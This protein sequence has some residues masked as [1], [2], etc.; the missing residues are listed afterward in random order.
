MKARLHKKEFVNLKRVAL[1]LLSSSMGLL[2]FF[3]ARSVNPVILQDEW[4]YLVSSRHVGYWDQA[5]PFDYSNYLFNI[6]YGSTAVCGTDFYSC[7]KGL[8][9]FW[10]SLL[11]F[12]LASLVMKHVGFYYA[13]ATAVA[14]GLSP[15]AV[16]VSLF[17]PEMMMFSLL[18]L[19]F[20]ILVEKPFQNE[21]TNWT[22][23]AGVLGLAALVK[24]H[25]L[26]FGIAV[27]VLLL[28]QIRE[29]GI[30]D[31]SKSVA[32]LAG[33]FL[34]ARFGAGFLVAGPKALD[35]LGS[36]SAGQALSEAFGGATSGETALESEAGPAQ[37]AF[38]DLTW[39]LTA[40]SL[41]TVSVSAIPVAILLIGL[42]G[43]VRKSVGGAS[44]R[45]IVF[46]LII[47][48]VYLIVVS[49]F[50]GWV[51]GTGDDHT[52]RILMRYFDFTHPLL[53][54]TSILAIIIGLRGVPAL[55]NRLLVTGGLFVSSNFAFSGWLATKGIQ[56]ADAP[57]LAG[58][59]PNL[60]ILTIVSL[61][62]AGVLVI[63]AFAWK[64]GKH[65]A[66]AG[67]LVISSLLGVTSMGQ[68][69]IAR[70]E[71]SQADIAGRA[72]QDLKPNLTPSN[73][74]LVS[75]SRFEGRIVSFWADDLYDLQ[76]VPP[77]SRINI[78]DPELNDFKFVVT[79]G[80]LELAGEFI[81]IGSGEGWTIAMKSESAG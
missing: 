35:I 30:R 15:L 73:T 81:E 3:R 16:Y 36:Y 66:V 64:R 72:L 55:P 56:I 21:M 9:A 54:T 10:F 47:L 60:Q 39:N 14:I 24:P 37:Q 38:S 76:L 62:Q 26:I 29:L 17:L 34:I 50:T 11:T 32:G 40:T 27:G 80:Q 25:A 61:V 13:L 45:A 7:A 46:S 31:F 18:V 42:V 70:G 4:I 28:S 78:L 58:L 63:L 6:I 49:L 69:Q 2:A 68:Y 33:G 22:A 65:I 19:I 74:I 20:W 43:T 5:P 23:A 51:T 1:L 59:V 44:S 79:I 71:D 77:A 52:T 48:G 41:A 75:T 12:L 53:L 57:Y 67:A 8:N